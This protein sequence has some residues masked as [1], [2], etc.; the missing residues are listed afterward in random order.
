MTLPLALWAGLTRVSTPALRLMLRRRV[1]RGK[2]IA[3]R[4]PEREAIDPTP[5]P[6][7]RLI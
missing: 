2:E 7:G 4:L 6:A 3:E 5:R 1:V